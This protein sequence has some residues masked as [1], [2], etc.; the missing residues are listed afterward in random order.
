MINDLQQQQ[1]AQN[2]IADTAK[3]TIEPF[4]SDNACNGNILR[5]SSD[6][7]LIRRGWPAMPRQGGKVQAS[8]ATSSHAGRTALGAVKVRGAELRKLPTLCAVSVRKQ[9]ER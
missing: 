8:S 9:A 4:V 3:P 2:Q 1:K 5:T 6:K 7:L